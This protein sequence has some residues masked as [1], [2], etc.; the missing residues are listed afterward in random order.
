[1]KINKKSKKNIKSL[2]VF[3]LILAFLSV[4]AY[5]IYQYI[6]SKPKPVN[7]SGINQKI[8]LNPPTVDQVKAGEDI[9]A[10]NGTTTNSSN[11]S[12]LITVASVNGNTVQIRAIINGAV[13]GDGTCLLTLSKGDLSVEKTA[14]TY[15]LP[16]SSTCQGF[17]I[18]RSELST[19]TWSINILTTI[20]N[21]TATATGEV[22]LD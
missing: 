6:N 8:D 14:T 9:K 16:T 11:L 2:I 7:N 3:I 20:G 17:D 1:M 18:S 19:G 13:S 10:S 21:E 15:A 5:F 4:G 22:V 12:S